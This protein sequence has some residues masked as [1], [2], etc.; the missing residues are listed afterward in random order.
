M[1]SLRP[2]VSFSWSGIGVFPKRDSVRKLRCAEKETS[3][4]F[5][6]SVP[7]IEYII[8]EIVVTETNEKVYEEPQILYK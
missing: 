6:L 4:A 8:A 2:I 3:I 5:S 1:Y 7:I